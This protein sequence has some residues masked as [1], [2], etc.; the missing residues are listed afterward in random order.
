VLVA[1]VTAIVG[2]TLAAPVIKSPLGP[3]TD[4]VAD[5]AFRVALVGGILLSGPGISTAAH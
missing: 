4:T 1:A 5:Q 3:L 2:M